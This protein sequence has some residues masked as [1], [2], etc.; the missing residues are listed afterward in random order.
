MYETS[1]RISGVKNFVSSGTSLVRA[2]PFS[3]V[4]SANANGSA[5][6]G[7]PPTASCLVEIVAGEL[8]EATLIAEVTSPRG[9]A[10][11][12]AGLGANATSTEPVCGATC[13][14]ELSAGAAGFG[15]LLASNSATRFSS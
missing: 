8:A 15:L 14:V 11:G 10:F 12:A 9:P 13:A 4:K 3:Q 1:A 6:A 5:F 2:F 7:F